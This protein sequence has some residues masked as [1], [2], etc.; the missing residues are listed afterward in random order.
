M[1]VVID[2]EH[3]GLTVSGSDEEQKNVDK[4][5]RQCRNSLFGLLGPALS[6]KCK[7]SPLAQL[8][9]WKVY[10]LPVL[11]SGL[12]AL[13]IRPT[14][15]KSLSVFN[16]KILRGFLKLS[17]SSP[18]PSLYFLTG[19]LP[20]AGRLHIDLLCMFYTILSNPQT[21][22]F[23]MV[24]YILMMTD[25]NS[26]TWSQHVRLL[27][28]QYELPDPLLMTQNSIIPSKIS[29][30]QLV[31]TK[32]T[33]YH[34]AELRAKA[35]SNSNLQYLNVQL[36][37]LSGLPHPA[38]HYILETRE[39][40]KCRAHI[41]ILSGDILSFEKLANQRG[42]SPHCR[43]CPCPV[44]SVQHILTECRATANIRERLH[45]ELLNL[46]HDLQP[47]NSLLQNNRNNQ[48]LTQ[49]LLDPTQ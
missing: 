19:E 6:Y 27:C 29:W 23:T 46:V 11:R 1:S 36:L 34:E 38:L 9:L 47:A 18:V 17:N 32:V 40:M 4:N 20:I 15:M 30:K 35:T 25:E 37:G 12:S 28:R 5:I 14:V 16:N 49:F 21:K 31:T 45:P 22:L 43:L 24:R 2:N 8:H 7:I 26:T 41:K 44:E 42:T 39:A 10:S 48:T 33:V 13:P 3:L